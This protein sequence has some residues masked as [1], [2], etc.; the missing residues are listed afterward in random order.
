M[1]STAGVAPFL[2]FRTAVQPFGGFLGA[3]DLSGLAPG[4]ERYLSF[5]WRLG[6]EGTGSVR[7]VRDVD[8]GLTVTAEPERFEPV[9]E[10]EY[11]VGL[12][13]PGCDRYPWQPYDPER[14]A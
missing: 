6:P 11:L 2:D 5:L 14:D 13:F 1:T 9:L 12:R 7:A 8:G 4:D 3:I 10:G